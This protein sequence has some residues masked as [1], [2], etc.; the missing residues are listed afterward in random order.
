MCSVNRPCHLGVSPPT[1]AS[2]LSLSQTA[3]IG[4]E[5]PNRLGHHVPRSPEGLG[6]HLCTPGHCLSRCHWLSSVGWAGP[7]RSSLPGTHRRWSWRSPGRHWTGRGRCLESRGSHK[8]SLGSQRSALFTRTRVGISRGAESG[9]EGKRQA[10]SGPCGLKCL[11]GCFCVW[12]SRPQKGRRYLN[13][14]LLLLLFFVNFLRSE[15]YT[16]L[17]HLKF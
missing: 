3:F 4:V 15:D 7:W 10:T 2:L 6:S 16:C 17:S 13:E 11:S 5:E 9:P 14:L 12:S 1:A 8:R